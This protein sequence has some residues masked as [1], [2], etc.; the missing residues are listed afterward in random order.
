MAITD[1]GAAQ[2]REGRGPSVPEGSHEALAATRE[3]LQDHL[4]QLADAAR[5]CRPSRGNPAHTKL[6]EQRGQV[7]AQIENHARA[8]ATNEGTRSE[9]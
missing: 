1:V 7:V 8:T 3:S 4:P 2:A 9:A 6:V 5:A